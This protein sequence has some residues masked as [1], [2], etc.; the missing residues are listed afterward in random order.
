MCI[1][2]C[3]IYVICQELCKAPIQAASHSHQNEQTKMA[4]FPESPY[5]W[6]ASEKN[7]VISFSASVLNENA[8]CVTRRHFD[9][10]KGIMTFSLPIFFHGFCCS[11]GYSRLHSGLRMLPFDRTLNTLHKDTILLNYHDYNR[12]SAAASVTAIT[13]D[14]GWTQWW[15]TTVYV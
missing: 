2:I 11:Q 12:N 10:H 15:L 5:L 13:V 1:P 3:D 8:F 4:P 7:R 14:N 9:S 6:F